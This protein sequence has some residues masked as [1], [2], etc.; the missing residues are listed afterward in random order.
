MAEAGQGQA[1]FFLETGREGKQIF[2]P[3]A[4]HYN[5]L[6]QLD[7]PGIAQGKGEFPPQ[8]P[9]FLAFLAAISAPH[10]PGAVPAQQLFQDGR[11]AANSTMIIAP[12]PSSWL[13]PVLFRAAAKVN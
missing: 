6:V 4:R 9:K 1:G 2:Q 7:Q 3:A 12:N 11:F 10:Q 5:I 8:L 13:L